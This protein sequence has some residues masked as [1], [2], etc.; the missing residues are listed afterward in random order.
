MPHKKNLPF[1]SIWLTVLDRESAWS[2]NGYLKK[3]KNICK[4]VSL[5]EYPY[6]FMTLCLPK[7]THYRLPTARVCLSHKSLQGIRDLKT[8]VCIMSAHLLA[9]CLWEYY[10]SKFPLR[11]LK[12]IKV[13][14]LQKRLHGAEW[15]LSPASV[16]LYNPSG[17]F[18]GALCACARHFPASEFEIHI[19][20]LHYHYTSIHSKMNLRLRHFT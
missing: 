19:I 3:K 4:A 17:Q 20:T 14:T 6:W 9:W 13:E 16:P 11:L 7:E 18:L 15:Y 1:W 5:P 12:Y 2:M 10:S 8:R